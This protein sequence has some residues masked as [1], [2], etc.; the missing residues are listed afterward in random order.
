MVGRTEGVCVMDRLGI[1]QIQKQKCGRGKVG[2]SGRDERKE[3]K[4]GKIWKR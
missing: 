4:E 3:G 2:V 1:C